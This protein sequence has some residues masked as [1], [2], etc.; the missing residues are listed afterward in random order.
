[1]AWKTQLRLPEA[2]QYKRKADDYGRG[3]QMVGA[4]KKERH[5]GQGELCPPRG[6]QQREERRSQCLPVCM[7]LL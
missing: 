3:S 4:E 6:A 7:G 5:E 1:M 2:Y